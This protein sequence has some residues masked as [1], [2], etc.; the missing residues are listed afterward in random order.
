MSLHDWHYMIHCFVPDAVA[1]A[2]LS[3]P[4]EHAKHPSNG[5]VGAK[6]LEPFVVDFALIDLNPSW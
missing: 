3:L 2:D 1:D 4:T 6:A 5:Y